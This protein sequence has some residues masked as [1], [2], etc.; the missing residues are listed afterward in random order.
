MVMHVDETRRRHHATR[1]VDGSDIR[2]VNNAGRRPCRGYASVFDDDGCIR[3]GWS[4]AAIDQSDVRQGDRSV[5]SA[6][7]KSRNSSKEHDERRH[8]AKQPRCW[9]SYPPRSMITAVPLALTMSMPPP[10]PT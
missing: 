3:Q 4:A 10:E 2:R 1:Q 6:A 9:L 8:A 7:L 5:R